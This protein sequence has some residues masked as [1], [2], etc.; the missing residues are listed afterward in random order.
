MILQTLLVL[1]LFSSQIITASNGNEKDELPKKSE[2]SKKAEPPKKSEPLKKAK[3]KEK[4]I[5]LGGAA[6]QSLSKS[7][8]KTPTTPS[9]IRSKK[10]TF[11]TNP[12]RDL[13]AEFEELLDI[14]ELADYIDLSDEKEKYINQ[15]LEKRNNALAKLNCHGLLER[16]N[17]IFKDSTTL[18]SIRLW[19]VLVV[20]INQAN[21]LQHFCLDPNG[22]LSIPETNPLVGELEDRRRVAS[23]HLQPIEAN[24]LADQPCCSMTIDSTPISRQFLS[25]SAKQQ[26]VDAMINRL[27]KLIEKLFAAPREVFKNFGEEVSNQNNEFSKKVSLSLIAEFGATNNNGKNWQ[28]IY[29]DLMCSNMQDSD[30]K[31]IRSALKRYTLSKRNLYYFNFF[32]ERIFNYSFEPV[33]QRA[34]TIVKII[35][36]LFLEKVSLMKK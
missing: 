31:M 6:S 5:K 25:S 33:A 29:Y 19:L 12:F 20:F 4:Q 35:L 2:S 13:K 36:A 21:R 24:K 32:L 1:L 18:Y 22:V 27:A 9:A 15:D 17:G 30:E 23:E 8:L 34:V 16:V 7:I 26:Q 14:D 10:V 11:D 3:S 28:R